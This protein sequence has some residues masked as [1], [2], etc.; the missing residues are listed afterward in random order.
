MIFIPLFEQLGLDGGS[1]PT[2]VG[3]RAEMGGI[4]ELPT[5]GYHPVLP[6]C[7]PYDCNNEAGRPGP[8]GCLEPS[9]TKP[10][11]L[12]PYPSDLS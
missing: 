5:V 8:Q 12:S 11:V 9:P 7:E 4:G 1:S 2:P 10:Y 3:S 6:S